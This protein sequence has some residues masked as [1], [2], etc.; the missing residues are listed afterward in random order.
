LNYWRTKSQAEVDFIAEKNQAIFPV[1]VK[2]HLAK[3]T[4]TRSIYSFINKYNSP[5]AII[6]SDRQPGSRIIE[7]S[8]L[9]FLPFW[10]G[11]PDGIV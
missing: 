1:K 5:Y 8:Q 11:I 7:S 10:L 4:S 9:V 3:M 2:S 6:F